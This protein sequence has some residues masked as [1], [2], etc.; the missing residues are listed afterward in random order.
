MT[1][2]FLRQKKISGNRHSFYL[3]FYPPIAHPDTGK[4]TRREFLG[5]YTYDKPKNPIDKKQNEDAKNIAENTRAKR[6]LEIQNKHFGFLSKDKQRADFIEYFKD[7]ADKRKASNHDN[8]ISAYHHLVK[9]SGG[10]LPFNDLDENICVEFREYLLKAKS[11]KSEYKTLSQ[12]SA[13]GYFNKLKATLKQAYKDGYLLID[14]NSKIERIKE[15]ETERQFLTMEELNTLANK[16]CTIPVLK[17]A[18]LFSALTGLRFSD[19]EK[20]IWG[21]VQYSKSEGYSLQFR[22]KKT[23]GVEVAPISEQA[24]KLLG[25]P[26]EPTQKVFQNLKYSTQNNT[27]LKEW[28]NSAGIRKHITFHCFRHTFATLQLSF[29]TDLYTVSKMLGHREIRTTQQYAK[30]IDKTKQVAA[31]KI[32][33]EF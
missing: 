17:K 25:E 7:L 15:A 26:Q 16:E 23:G 18:G 30:V 11:N 27:Y 13:H 6:Q 12:N 1:K 19:I 9:F 22:Q 32:K 8:W 31:N 14:L 28:L 5:L 21:Q 3:D 24:Y 10:S 2:V 29:G 20:L 33:L 4:H